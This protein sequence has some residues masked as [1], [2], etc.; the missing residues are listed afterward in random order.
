MAILHSQLPFSPVNVH[1]HPTVDTANA[2][3]EGLGPRV[4]IILEASTR[5]KTHLQKSL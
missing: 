3:I 5:G 4:I 2:A 1:V